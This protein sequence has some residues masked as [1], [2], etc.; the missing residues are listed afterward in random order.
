MEGLEGLYI[1]GTVWLL[2]K[3]HWFLMNTDLSRCECHYQWDWGI[4]SIWSI[5]SEHK[6]YLKTV[7]TL[8]KNYD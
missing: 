2:P 8:R 6:E 1:W 4:Y 5:C 3:E 7:S